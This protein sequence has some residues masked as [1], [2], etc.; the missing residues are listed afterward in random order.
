MIS[1]YSTKL[2]PINNCDEKVTIMYLEM[3][4]VLLATKLFNKK[5]LTL[6]VDSQAAIF[7]FSKAL[8]HP[9]SANLVLLAWNSMV[10]RRHFNIF[11]VPSADNI[12][13]LPTRVHKIKEK[14][15]NNLLSPKT[16]FC[17]FQ[18]KKMRRH[19][20]TKMEEFVTHHAPH[21]KHLVP[22]FTI[23]QPF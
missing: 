5:Y 19:A 17:F 21:S 6:A 15:V 8:V 20:L 12:G 10:L 7:A 22:Q 18:V 2:T 9:Q 3:L 11:Y 23:E 13:D 16:Q 4:A 14:A 1:W